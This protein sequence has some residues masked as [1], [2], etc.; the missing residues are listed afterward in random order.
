MAQAL[1][2]LY[3]Q[4][5]IEELAVALNK[6]YSAFKQQA[7]VKAVFNQEWKSK[8]LKSRMRHIA[9]CLHQ[10]LPIQYSQQLEILKKVAPQYSG[11]LALFF[12]DFV[13]VYGI[14][15]P[16]LSIDALAYFTQYSSSEFAVRPFIVTYE[17]RMLTQ[18]IQ[19][20]KNKNIHVRRLA[21]EGIRP[22]L[23]WAMAL[24]KFKKDPSSL[25]PILELLKQDG[26]EYVRRSVANC[27]NDISK[28]HP[29]L[30][31]EIV[32]KWKGISPETDWIV[33]HASRGLLKQG[34][35]EALAAFGL[36]HKA[37]AHIEH[38]KLSHKRIT[39]GQQLL[40]DFTLVNDEKRETEFRVEYKMYF[41]KAN[42]KQAGKIFQIGTYKLKAGESLPIERKHA[43]VN[44][45]TRKHY[46]GKHH[47]TIVV[48]G[49]EL[50]EQDFTLN[51]PN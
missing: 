26:S 50:A 10:F 31:I 5:Y 47:I 42:G 45:T 41:M 1:K 24:P 46:A 9:N 20:A 14:S 34:H 49:K 19:W 27:L 11:F 21:S 7:F 28:D 51:I 38:L 35:T 8:E 12:P 44:R 40:F 17:K 6:E 2:D 33:K 48:N 32:N 30:V 23:P 4:A 29:Q 39:L 15:E 25:L 22:R 3:T 16:D 36:N 43:F 18:H 13:E 37:K